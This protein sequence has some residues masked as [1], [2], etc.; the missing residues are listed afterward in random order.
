MPAYSDTTVQPDTTYSYRVFAVNGASDSLPSNTVMTTTA[1][2]AAPS[3]LGGIAPALGA[4]PPTVSLSW[5]DNSDSESRFTIQRA[6]NRTFTRELTTFAVGADVAAYTDAAVLARKAY[7]YRVLGFNGIGSSAWSRTIRVV[8]G[9]LP[10]APSNLTFV[11]S[12]A[13]SVTIAW[14]DNAGNER[15]FQVQMSTSGAQGPWSTIAALPPDT[16]TYTDTGLLSGHTYLYRVRA[17][18]AGGRSGFSNW[19]YGRTLP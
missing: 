16:V 7:F 10:A 18:S 19:T 9:L 5:T 2:P 4:D 8:P 13:N 1:I 11:T 17:L 3:G 14:T 6:T 15:N 12:T